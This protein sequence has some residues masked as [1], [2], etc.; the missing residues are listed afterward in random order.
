MCHLVIGYG[1]CYTTVVDEKKI[2]IYW[3]DINCTSIYCRLQGEYS[4]IKPTYIQNGLDQIDIR[5]ASACNTT[6]LLVGRSRDRF[7][8]MSLDFSVAYL[9]PT[10]PRP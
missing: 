1:C 10:V 5:K 8:V 7:P 9:L 6:A 4:E 2:N 3:T